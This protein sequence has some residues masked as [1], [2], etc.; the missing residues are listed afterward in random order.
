[1]IE[2]VIRFGVNFNLLG[3]EHPIVISILSEDNIGLFLIFD[4]LNKLIVK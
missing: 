1:V 4:N 2:L 3:I